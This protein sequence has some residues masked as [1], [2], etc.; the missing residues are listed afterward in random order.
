MCVCVCVRARARACVRA[1]VH[2][3]RRQSY[4]LSNVSLKFMGGRQLDVP[5]DLCW[6]GFILS[7]MSDTD[8]LSSLQNY[9]IHKN[10][11]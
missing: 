3:Y 9:F 8:A 1:C 5:E 6:K 11:T 4:E 10:L 7:I 2:V